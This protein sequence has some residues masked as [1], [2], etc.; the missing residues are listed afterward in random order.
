[1]IAEELA[2]YCADIGSVKKGNFGWAVVHG[3]Q[4]RGERQI[5]GLV[6][7]LVARLSEGTRVALGFECPL[8]VPVAEDPQRLTAG[9]SVD[10]NKAWSAGAGANALATGLTETAW[11]LE[12]VHRGLADA[13]LSPPPAYLEWREFARS[14][15]GTFFWEA[16][17]TGEAKAQRTGKFGHVADALMACKEFA[18]RLPDPDCGRG[19]GPPDAVR[20]LIG[21]A[22]L[23]SGWS[24][25]LDL[26]RTRCL[27]VRPLQAR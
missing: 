10:G 6:D 24:D 18:A 3:G 26:L 27:V 7:D 1:M 9:R 21:S 22:L 12:H 15:A 25:D 5:G 2:I 11:I 17:V 4:Q 19:G 23:W 14:E 8:W 16:F 20:S 13:G